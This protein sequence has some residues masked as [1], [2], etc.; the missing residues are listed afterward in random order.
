MVK[1]WSTK[2][3]IK[4]HCT[5]MWE[6]GFAVKQILFSLSLNNS[7]DSSFEEGELK[8]PLNGPKAA[9]INK[10]FQKAVDFAQKWLL[11]NELEIETVKIN[12]RLMGTQ[13]M[14]KNVI[15]RD[16]YSYLAFIGKRH[17]YDRLR[18]GLMKIVLQYNYLLP[19]IKSNPLLYQKNID[20]FAQLTRIVS[21]LL[22]SPQPHIYLRELD[23]PGID[24]KFIETHKRIISEILDAVLPEQYIDYTKNKSHEFA[25]RYGFLSKPDL[26]RFRLL[27]PEMKLPW[28][29]ASCPDLTLDAQSF[30]Q[31]R[32]ECKN[33]VVCEN[34]IS[35]LSLPQFANTI[36]IFGS[37]YGFRG[38]KQAS[39]LKTGKKIIYWGDLDTHGLAILREFRLAMHPCEVYS[40]FMDY[41]TLQQHKHSCVEESKPRTDE[42]D[43]L[44]ENEALAYRA[45]QEN[46]LGS[47][48]G[49]K[50]MRL[51]Q[52]KIPWHEV[53]QTL[54]QM[55]APK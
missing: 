45:L 3:D 4:N 42:L 33:V 15:F 40:I 29:D 17:E 24:T 41:E 38:I 27:D 53:R 21:F 8:I 54:T 11:Q 52:E 1:A 49:F 37:G 39:W 26:I 9:D 22:Q 13:L 16:I 12:T 10:D 14:P 35:F 5:D 43:H 7:Y 47:A 23:L 50:H 6:R 44:T 19:I 2:K 28:I 32:I 48:L 36:A 34:E 30:S 20:I 46:Q 31:L 18:T 51:E 25:E 55:L